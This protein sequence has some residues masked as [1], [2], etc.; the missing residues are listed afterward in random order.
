MAGL[1]AGCPS[2]RVERSSGMPHTG[3]T[4]NN[5]IASKPSVTIVVDCSGL[6]EPSDYCVSESGTVT[7]KSLCPPP[8]GPPVTLSWSD[9][10]RSLFPGYNGNSYTPEFGNDFE[11]KVGPTPGDYALCVNSPKCQPPPPDGGGLHEKV[12]SK[13][14]TLDVYTTTETEPPPETQ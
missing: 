3:R 1:L 6:V 10:T 8:Q 13:T 2:R 14:G 5:G 12:K 7:F 4:C 9:E 11:L